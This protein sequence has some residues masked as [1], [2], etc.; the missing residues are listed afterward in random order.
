[1]VSVLKKWFDEFLGEEQFDEA[2]ILPEVIEDICAVARG[3]A[4]K[5][6]VAF[7]TGSVQKRKGRKI[8]TIDGL[9]LKSYD[10]SSYATSFTT[11]DLPSTG[12]Y[13]TVHSH[14]SGSNL[15]SRQDKRLFNSYGW[16]HLIVAAPY[17]RET[18]ASYNKYGERIDTIE[19]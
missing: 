13:G 17:S 14:P 12:V 10:A 7:L 19:Y 6:M 2:H 9:Y 3:S 1:M 11:H 16:F 4:P 5:E 18:I 8:L 15:P